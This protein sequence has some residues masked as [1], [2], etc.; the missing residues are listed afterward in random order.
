[1]CHKGETF[2]LNVFMEHFYFCEA[3]WILIVTKLSLLTTGEKY[4]NIA[5][6]ITLTMNSSA[7]FNV[8]KI[9]NLKLLSHE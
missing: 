2:N 5:C 1:M 4:L 9:F 6:D 3:R 7:G 8:R